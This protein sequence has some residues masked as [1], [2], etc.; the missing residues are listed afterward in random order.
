M[1]TLRAVKFAQSVQVYGRQ[2]TFI[3]ASDGYEICTDR[4][5]VQIYHKVSK[6]YTLT[7]WANVAWTTPDEP[8]FK[9]IEETPGPSRPAPKVSKRADELLKQL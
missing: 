3:K 6:T 5:I 7:S 2:E 9:I 1:D 8:F 4:S